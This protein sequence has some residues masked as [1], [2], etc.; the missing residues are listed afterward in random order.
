MKGSGIPDSVGRIYSISPVQIELYS[1]RLLL[2]NVCGPKSFEDIRT[3]D[4]IVY[5]TFQDAAIARNLVKD[6]KIWID[7]MNEANHHQ[8]NIHLLRKLFATILLHCE[9][10]NHKAFLLHCKDMLIAD[11]IHKYNKSFANNDE[12]RRF[13]K[14]DTKCGDNDSNNCGDDTNK[15]FQY[16]FGH[17]KDTNDEDWNVE[18]TALNMCLVDIQC[19]LQVMMNKSLSDF[20]LPMINMMREKYVQNTLL[21]EYVSK[22]DDFLPE[23]AKEFYDANFK[24]MNSNQKEVFERIKQLI[25]DETNE[26]KLIFLDAPGGTGK[27]FTLNI[28]ISWIIMN[29]LDVAISAASG[30]A[31]NLLYLGKTAHNRFKLPFHPTKD[32]MCNIKKQSKLANFL[33]GMSIGIVDEGSMLNS[34]LYETIDKTIKDFVPEEHS[35]KKFG[36]KLML[37]SGDSCQLL[38]VLEKANRSTI[39][40]HTIKKSDLWDNVE[41]LKLTQNMR[42]HNEK[43]KYPDDVE[44]H[45]ELENH[46]EWLLKLGENCL[47]KHG[48]VDDSNIIE[49]PHHM[50]RQSKD[51]VIQTVYDDFK[52]NIGDKEYFKSR[53]VFAGTNE[54]VDEVNDEMVDEMNGE[55][56]VFTSVDTV[57][58]YD[59]QTMFPTEYLNS[60]NLSGLPIHELTL[61]KNAV[62]ILLQNMDIKAG[63]CNGTR[64]LVKEIGRY[65]LLLEKLNH[66]EGDKNTTLLLLRIPMRY[67]G[68]QFP[69]EL[70]RLQF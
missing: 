22:E 26:G 56:H 37:I 35:H 5:E 2:T 70:K 8:T 7:C 63:H 64:Y 48:S 3:F 57:G 68:K 6:D 23:V 14:P 17:F 21:E 44:F 9:V 67:G 27:T 10:S 55:E 59:S 39:V 36:G 1:L 43:I 69:F 47:P 66:K 15:Q 32:S 41:V 46:E 20:N 18:K 33:A 16:Y 54:I 28:V 30:I 12:L 19:M 50:C 34:L 61:K 29:N 25:E 45:K 51:E 53:I 11:L 40:N 65:R 52:S 13:I 49:V 4:G 38:P 24:K 62:V 42:V 58:D 31:A 60:L